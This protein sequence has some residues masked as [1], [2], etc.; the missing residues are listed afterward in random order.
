MPEVEAQFRLNQETNGPYPQRIRSAGYLI[1][2]VVGDRIPHIRGDAVLLLQALSN[3]P[4]VVRG[5]CY[6]LMLI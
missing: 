3:T 1:P 5:A 2:A 4:V 6:V